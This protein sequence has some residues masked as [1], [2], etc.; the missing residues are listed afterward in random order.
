MQSWKD[1]EQH[2]HMFTEER[3]IIL[4]EELPSYSLVAGGA[5]EA[6]G[7]VGLSGGGGVGVG[8]VN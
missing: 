7:V 1:E 2:A 6:G 8:G 3:P 5:G 4:C